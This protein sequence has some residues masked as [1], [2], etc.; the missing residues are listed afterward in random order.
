[1]TELPFFFFFFFFLCI[2]LCVYLFYFNILY[3]EYGLK[4]C[5]CRALNILYLEEYTLSLLAEY[6]FYIYCD[7]VCILSLFIGKV[8]MYLVYIY[9]PRWNRRRARFDTNQ[10]G[11]RAIEI[12]FSPSPSRPYFFPISFP[13]CHPSSSLCQWP[14]TIIPTPS[15]VFIPPLVLTTSRTLSPSP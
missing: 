14:T 3:F 8:V 4:I 10:H 1:M 2:F 5:T 12:G 13:V 7:I 6:I 11:I 9:I 15:P